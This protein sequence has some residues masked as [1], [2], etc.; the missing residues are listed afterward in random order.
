M[1][2]GGIMGRQYGRPGQV[3][4][5]ILGVLVCAG[6]TGAQVGAMGAV[7]HTFLG[8]SRVT[9]IAIGCGIVI[10]YSAVGGMKAVVMTDIVQFVLL[11]VGMPVALILGIGRMG[12]VGGLTSAVP[13]EHL[14]LF[15]EHMTPVALV[16]LFLS[17]MLGETLV[18]PY[19]QR[20]L[21]GRDAQA[22]ARGSF[23]AGLF[24]IPFFAITGALGLVALALRPEL[25]SNQALPFVVNELLPV[26]IRGFVIAGVISIVMSSADSFLN[27]ASVALVTDVINPFRRQDLSDQ[28]GL[29]VMKITTLVVGVGAVGFALRIENVLDILLFAYNF[30]AP[31]VLVPLLAV[32]LGVKATTRTFL[33][34]ASGGVIGLSIWHW[35]LKDPAGVDALVVGVFANLLVFSL[36]HWIGTRAGEPVKASA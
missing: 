10:A 18:P 6:I 16:S 17:F 34:G 28:T 21:I 33:A 13:V 14:H 8:T 7:F 2:T 20:L 11:A 15:N 31:V 3:I 5:G 32:L 4:T 24:S 19:T 1:S 36:V 23:Y 12:G 26:G 25:D 29:R 9:G 22:T 35:L 27:A 30:W